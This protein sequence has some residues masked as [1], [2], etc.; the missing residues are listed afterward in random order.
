M[1]HV[2]V[3]I[4]GAGLSGVGAAVHLRQ[5][6][7]GKPSCTLL[8]EPKTHREV[9]GIYFAIPASVQTLIC[10]RWGTTS[11]PGPRRKPLRM[12]LLSES[13]LIKLRDEFAVREH[14]AWPQG[15]ECLLG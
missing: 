6:C 4:V 11:N 7:P 2:N 13:T 5:K 12:A 14:V 8:E 15:V 1:D 3:I 10:T 9:L